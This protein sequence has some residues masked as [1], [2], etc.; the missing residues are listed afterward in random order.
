MRRGTAAPPGLPRPRDAA[1]SQGFHP[2]LCTTAPPG[3][4]TEQTQADLCR[5]QWVSRRGISGEYGEGCGP[6]PGPPVARSS[7]RAMPGG[8]KRWN[9]GRSRWSSLCW[10]SRF[11]YYRVIYLCRWIYSRLFPS[12]MK[13][14]V[15]M[16]WSITPSR[17][18]GRSRPPRRPGSWSSCAARAV[19]RLDWVA[20]RGRGHPDCRFAP[21]GNF[22]MFEVA[23]TE[24]VVADLRFLKRVRGMSYST[25]S[26]SNSRR[27]RWRIRET[28]N[29]YAPTTS[30][31]GKR[32]SVPIGCSMT[33]MES[34]GR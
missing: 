30:P 14:S 27:N 13:S 3:L 23:F 4:K 32:E 5:Y 20:V 28:V 7:R 25:P 22:S 26:S 10:S 17:C 18:R 16:S 29:R 11:P 24:S 19:G 15:T 9:C 2:W 8:A 1:S 21:R 12:C 6:R 31:L 34:T 33:W